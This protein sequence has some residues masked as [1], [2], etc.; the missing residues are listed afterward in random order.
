MFGYVLDRKLEFLDHKNVDLKKSQNLNFSKG[1]VH[2][3]CQNFL[4][5]SFFL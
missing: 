1:V 5:G 4:I 3:F 2:G